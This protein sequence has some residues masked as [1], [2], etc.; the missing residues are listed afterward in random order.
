[1]SQLK[2]TKTTHVNDSLDF[3]LVLVLV[4]VF[5]FIQSAL[6]FNWINFN[7]NPANIDKGLGF[8]MHTD[9]VVTFK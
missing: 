7:L 3:S 8:L 2:K 4:T 6:H 9:L 1:M 5:T